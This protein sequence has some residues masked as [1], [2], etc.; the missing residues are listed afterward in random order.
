MGNGGDVYVGDR[1]GKNSWSCIRCGDQ[2]IE[3]M[4]GVGEE[5]MEGTLNVAT[6]CFS[7]TGVATTPG[8]LCDEEADIVIPVRAGTEAAA[9]EST[10]FVEY[11]VPKEEN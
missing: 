8:L 4:V 6:P 5:W 7:V 9:A 1:L 10:V 2:G 11:T 3:G